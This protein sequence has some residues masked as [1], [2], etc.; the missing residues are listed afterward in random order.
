VTGAS[1]GCEQHRPGPRAT[2]S[3]ARPE[4]GREEQV[5]DELRAAGYRIPRAYDLRATQTPGRVPAGK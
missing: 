3:T 5:L 4:R 2:T 1:P